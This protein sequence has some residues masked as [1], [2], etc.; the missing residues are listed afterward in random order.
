MPDYL[1]GAYNGFVA[2]HCT[3]IDG[4]QHEATAEDAAELAEYVRGRL[5]L[6]LSL[7]CEGRQRRAPQSSGYDHEVTPIR[8]RP[9][10]ASKLLPRVHRVG[11]SARRKELNTAIA[12]GP[13][14]SR[15]RLSHWLSPSARQ[16]SS[17]TWTVRP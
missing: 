13:G 8:G 2:E 12:A 15:V 4:I 16:G 5:K 3:L 17:T 10:D 11:I 1:I 14:S 9:K 6:A 7:A